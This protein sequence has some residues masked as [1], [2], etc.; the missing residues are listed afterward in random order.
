M[1]STYNALSGGFAVDLSRARQTNA[2]Q[3][4][5]KVG[6]KYEKM[7][8]KH[9]EDGN[10]KRLTATIISMQMLVDGIKESVSVTAVNSVIAR[11]NPITNTIKIRG[12]WSDNHKVW[13]IARY[14]WVLHLLVRLGYH[15]HELVVKHLNTFDPLP[16]WLNPSKT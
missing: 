4:K 11:M 2:S 8:C 14:N 16:D 9:L 3:Y 7:V 5:I 6:S 1:T 10:S 12:Q 13:V 15:E